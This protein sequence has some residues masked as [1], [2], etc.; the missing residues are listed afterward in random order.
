MANAFWNRLVDNSITAAAP[1]ISPEHFQ[2]SMLAVIGSGSLTVANVRT[3]YGLAAGT[4]AGDEFGDLVTSA[5]NLSTALFPNGST[6]RRQVHAYIVK[7]I[8]S[9]AR[10]ASSG[11][12]PNPWATG[13]GLRLEARSVLVQEHGG[14]GLLVGSM[15]SA[16]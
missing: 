14:T 15:V 11:L 16:T 6:A 12:T 2:A 5:Q 4:E 9:S 7:K 1:Y 13:N 3:Q 10:L 8:C